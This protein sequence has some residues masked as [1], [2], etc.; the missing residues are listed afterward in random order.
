MNDPFGVSGGNKITDSSFF[1]RGGE[2]GEEKREAKRPGFRE[3]QHPTWNPLQILS[4]R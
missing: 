3:A 4:G 2:H 1:R